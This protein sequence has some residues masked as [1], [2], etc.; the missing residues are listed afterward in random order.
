MELPEL[1]VHITKHHNIHLP[2]I[3]NTV[4]LAT[5]RMP[6]LSPVHKM[7]MLLDKVLTQPPAICVPFTPIKAPAFKRLVLSF[8][9][10][11]RMRPPIIMV[12]DSKW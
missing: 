7:T 8:A 6:W 12:K 1:L 9:I 3:L 10:H 2:M 5:K 11:R 4:V